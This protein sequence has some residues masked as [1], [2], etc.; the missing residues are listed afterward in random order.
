MARAVRHALARR[1]E[2]GR[3]IHGICSL[4]DFIPTF[5]AAKGEADLVEGEAGL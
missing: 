1:N 5:A 3:V 4:Q 2:P